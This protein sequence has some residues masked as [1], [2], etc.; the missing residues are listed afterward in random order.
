[1]LKIFNVDQVRVM[2]AKKLWGDE[3]EEKHIYTRRISK[4][5]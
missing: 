4:N 5:T 1:M 2:T 3:W